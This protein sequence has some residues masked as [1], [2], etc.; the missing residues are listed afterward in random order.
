MASL[1]RRKSL[2]ESKQFASV[3]VYPERSAR[4]VATL[5][6]HILRIDKCRPNP[7]QLTRTESITCS[8]NSPKRFETIR[9]DLHDCTDRSN[10]VG[11]ACRACRYPLLLHAHSTPTG[12]YNKA[13]GRR[14][15]GAP[16]EKLST[17]RDVNRYGPAKV[18]GIRFEKCWFSGIFLD[19]T[20][21]AIVGQ[22]LASRP[23]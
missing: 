23:A 2:P 9:N 21:I 22:L 7:K 6:K 5:R 3:R 17:D 15:N 1:T 11:T 10:S 12:F 8:L 16:Q 20:Q 4:P 13:R 18:R 14:G 19:L